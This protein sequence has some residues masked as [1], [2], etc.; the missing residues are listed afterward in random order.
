MG[1]PDYQSIMLPLLKLAADKKEHWTREAIE[2]LSRT[3][4]L[5]DQEAEQLLPSG[6]LPVFYDRVHWAL[7]YLKH[8]GLLVGTRRGYF[9]ITE[10]GLK[11]LEEKPERIDA[12]Y[13][14]RF[15]EF[16]DY[17]GAN[18]EDKEQTKSIVESISDRT[19]EEIFEA[20]YR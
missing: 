15:P 13:L 9:Q 5:S 3:F 12:R 18:K 17:I 19:P 14:R 4:K 2:T 6:K 11:V 7:S 20:S 1:I 8:S 16:L 10:R